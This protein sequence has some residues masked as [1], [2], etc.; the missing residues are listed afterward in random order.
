MV[1][2]LYKGE[3]LITLTYPDGSEIQCISTLNKD[4]LTNRG[5]LSVDGL[6]DL[7][8][9]KIIPSDLIIEVDSIDVQLGKRKNLSPLDKTFELAIK[10]RWEDA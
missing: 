8:T 2:E 4:I 7:S 9:N 6:V 3:C 1:N 5:L 10:R